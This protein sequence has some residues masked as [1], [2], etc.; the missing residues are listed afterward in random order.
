MSGNDAQMLNG[1]A[2]R[3][4]WAMRLNADMR[5]KV[6]VRLVEIILDQGSTPREI[7]SA[8]SA[9]SVFD[10][11][12]VE[13]IKIDMVTGSNDALKADEQPYVY[14]IIDGT[15]ELTDDTDVA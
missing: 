6:I 12:D 10:R 4:G 3:Q 2:H 5:E 8:S 11:L 15:K 13:R 7:T 14:E 9:L 1:L